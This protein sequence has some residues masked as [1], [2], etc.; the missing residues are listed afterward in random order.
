MISVM[1]EIQIY[2]NINEHENEIHAE[3]K[4]KGSNYYG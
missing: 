4:D 2:I 3:T 1:S